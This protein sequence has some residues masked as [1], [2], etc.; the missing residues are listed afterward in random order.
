MINK[1][2]I[3]RLVQY[4]FTL[5]TL[6]IFIVYWACSKIL[7]PDG[8]FQSFSQVLSLLPGKIGVYLRAAFYHLAC[9]NTSQDISIGFLTIFSHRDTTIEEGV[10]IGPQCNI[11][12]CKIGSNTLLGSGVHILSGKNQHNFDD[13]D[14][15]IQFQGGHFEKIEIGKDCWLG[16]GSIVMVEVK[17]QTVIAA[18]SVITKSFDVAVVC[19]GNPAKLIKGRHKPAL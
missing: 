5:M 15:P 2:I 11:G 6:P 18:G 12:K 4:G 13:P 17:E 10:Y 19:G 7:E 8:T 16:N 14:M 1:K 9:P 3:K